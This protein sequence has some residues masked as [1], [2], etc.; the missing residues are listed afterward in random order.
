MT[1]NEQ[2]NTI[3]CHIEHQWIPARTGTYLLDDNVMCLNDDA[4]LGY[5]KDWPGIFEVINKEG[6][7]E[8]YHD[9]FDLRGGEG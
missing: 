2:D 5:T 7:A 9:R 6:H 4:H 1:K 3:F 8:L